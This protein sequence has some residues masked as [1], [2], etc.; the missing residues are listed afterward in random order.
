MSVNPEA[1]GLSPERLSRI[2]AR[3]EKHIE[4]GG[5]A[6]GLGLILRR[7][8]VGYFETWN[9]REDAIFRIFSMTKAVTGVAAM[10]LFEEGAF[11][12]ADPIS[13][14]M[15]EFREMRIAVESPDPASG[16]MALTGTLPAFRWYANRARPGTTGS[17]RT[18]LAG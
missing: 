15:P 2:R 17:A 18:C 16:R 3:M 14:F 13:N 6:G 8:Q 11:A 4:A 1:A 10:M 9:M 12:L 5:M 7:G